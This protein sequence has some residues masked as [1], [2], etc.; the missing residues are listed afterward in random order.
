[1]FCHKDLWTPANKT[2]Q[3]TCFLRE[4]KDCG[5]FD[6]ACCKKNNP[7]PQPPTQDDGYH[8]EIRTYGADAGSG[9]PYG[10]CDQSRNEPYGLCTA[11]PPKGQN[12]NNTWFYVWSDNC[13]T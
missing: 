4:L 5:T 9:G 6:K 2:L 11:C 8:Y 13:R 3:N 7:K 1:M 12:I 10:W